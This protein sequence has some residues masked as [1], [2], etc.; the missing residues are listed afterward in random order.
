[1]IPILARIWWLVAIRG[2]AGI[3]VGLAAF[4]WPGMT[5]AVLALLFGAY[6]LVDGA[7]ALVAGIRMTR[8]IHS[9][10]VL[11]LE[12]VGGIILGLVTFVSPG[13]TVLVVLAFVA[14]WSIISGVVEI[15]VA[16]RLRKAVDNEWLLIVS[17]VISVIYGVLLLT[18]PS[19]GALALVWLTGAYALL[20]GTLTL[21]L[22]FRLRGLRG[23]RRQP[24][25]SGF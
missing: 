21:A 22:S 25:P 13:A 19:A 5:L 7:F 15:A 18:F 17:G 2:I 11:V 4:M 10:W 23:A 8:E 6:V 14:A 16:V 9:W 3:L 20:V 1:M 12:G 24:A